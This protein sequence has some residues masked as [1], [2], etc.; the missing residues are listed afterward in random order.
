[1]RYSSMVARPGIRFASTGETG[2]GPEGIQQLD[3]ALDAASGAAGSATRPPAVGADEGAKDESEHSHA[4]T[5][6]SSAGPAHAAGECAGPEIG[7]R[8]SGVTG[9]G[10]VGL[11]VILT[12]CAKVLGYL[13]LT[14]PLS[15]AYTAFTLAEKFLLPIFPLGF[16]SL[17]PL[18]HEF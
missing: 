14:R 12:E 17:V 13:A 4:A 5:I 1:M 15:S 2:D 9:E 10:A 3:E 7:A 18:A 6:V 8:N 11:E 16:P